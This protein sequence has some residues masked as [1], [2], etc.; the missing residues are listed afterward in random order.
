[1]TTRTTSTRPIKASFLAGKSAPAMGI[2]LTAICLSIILI[3]SRQWGHYGDSTATPLARNEARPGWKFVPGDR[4]IY[5]LRYSGNADL[6]F[7]AL[8]ANPAAKQRTQSFMTQSFKVDL[9]ASLVLTVVDERVENARIAFKLQ[10]QALRITI[11]GQDSAAIQDR[12]QKD[13]DGDFYVSISYEGK[14]QSV[15]FD[16]AMSKISRSLA[17]TLLASIQFVFPERGAP[18]LGRWETQE[19][20]PNGHYVAQ[21]VAEPDSGRAVAGDGSGLK[22]FRK[23][24]VKYL[25]AKDKSNEAGPPMTIAPKGSSIASF[26]IEAGQLIS[27]EGTES[28]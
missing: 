21:Y 16:P 15:R 6:D 3:F 17:S 4:W 20:Y 13:L 28:Q 8:F 10:E 7:G 24:K 23:T 14:I 11:D 27:L 19:D 5:K 26:D 18:D 22:R 1:M 2:A 25:P 12:V 9:R